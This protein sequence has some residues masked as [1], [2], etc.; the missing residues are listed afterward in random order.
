[1]KA[2]IIIEKSFDVETKEFS[3]DYCIG[4]FAEFMA[5]EGDYLDRLAEVLNRKGTAGTG[6]TITYTV[7]LEK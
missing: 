6:Y 3:K 1:M 7:K 2:K 5:D 4:D